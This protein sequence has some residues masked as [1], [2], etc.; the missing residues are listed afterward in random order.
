MDDRETVIV[1]GPRQDLL[2][3]VA[4]RVA[5]HAEV[6]KFD[7]HVVRLREALETAEAQQRDAWAACRVLSVQIDDAADDLYLPDL[8]DNG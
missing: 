2:R 7:S 3:L 4:Q 6:R 1:P 5:A 8:P